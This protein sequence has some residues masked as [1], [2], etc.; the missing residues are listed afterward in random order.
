MMYGKD[1]NLITPVI[2]WSLLLTQMERQLIDLM[3]DLILELPEQ[4]PAPSKMGI[5]KFFDDWISAPYI[6]QLQD[7]KIILEGLKN[8]DTMAQ[9][10][11]GKEF[12]LLSTNEQRKIIQEELMTLS[13][14]KSDNND[15]FIRFRYLLIGGYYTSDIGF[16]AIGYIGNIPLNSF[17]GPPEEV[18]ELIR[19]EHIKLGL[20]SN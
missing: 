1:P 5:A 12:V 11:F 6:E 9:N 16:K 20:I 4:Y 10:V 8:L 7:R 18:R 3:S 13:D 15:F 17:E 14:K 2:T 19:Q